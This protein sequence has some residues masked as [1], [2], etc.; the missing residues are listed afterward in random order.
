ME[1]V[2]DHQTYKR[3]FENVSAYSE[4]AAAILQKDNVAVNIIDGVR[5]AVIYSLLFAMNIFKE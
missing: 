4:H 2:Y 5:E 3:C 1:L